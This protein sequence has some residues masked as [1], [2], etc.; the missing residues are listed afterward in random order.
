VHHFDTSENDARTSELLE[1]E[2]WPRSSLDGSMIL[3]NDVV[4]ILALSD[5]NVRAVLSVVILDSSLVRATLIDGGIGDTK[6]V[7]NG[8]VRRQL[9]LPAHCLA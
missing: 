2:H 1:A 7:F 6:I 8:A 3:L 9:L 5:H 4:E